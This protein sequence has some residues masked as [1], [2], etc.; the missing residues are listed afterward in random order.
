MER[1]DNGWLGER[2]TMIE[3]GQ[4]IDEWYIPCWRVLESDETNVPLVVAW[5]IVMEV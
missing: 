2:E 3:R 4:W 5:S 1:R